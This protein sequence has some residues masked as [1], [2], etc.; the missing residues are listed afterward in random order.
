MADAEVRN[1]F[2]F[3]W[4]CELWPSSCSVESPCLNRLHFTY[5]LFHEEGKAISE[6]HKSFR[7]R[8]KQSGTGREYLR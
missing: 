4:A 7:R 2:C 3:R 1:C 5:R 8:H 6:S